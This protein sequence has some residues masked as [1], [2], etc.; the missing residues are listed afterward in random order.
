MAKDNARLIEV[1]VMPL[2][3]WLEL[4][5]NPPDGV[6]FVD[7]KFP[8]NKHLQE[9]VDTIGYRSEEE[10][11]SL[12][13]RLLIPSTSLG[14]DELNFRTLR[15]A[16][17]SDHPPELYEAMIDRQYY[18]RLVPYSA[19][20]SRIPPWEGITWVLDLLPHFPNQVLSTLNAYVLAH[21]QILPDGRL[22]GLQDTVSVIR[23]KF[24]GLPG[25]QD[26]KVEF[27]LGRSPRDFEHL[28]ERLYS[29]MGYETRLTPYQKDGGR[30]VVATRSAPGRVER[31]LVECKR[32]FRP[33]GVEQVRA[34]LGVVSAEKVNKGVVATTSRFTV[35]ASKFA[36]ENHLELVSGDQLVRL[37]NEHLGAKW[38]LHVDRLVT[39]SQRE[40]D[41]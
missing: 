40:N 1:D 22:E 33:I 38:P 19:G 25:T 4:L 31:L 6:L 2:D 8:T 7:Y 39:A 24:I 41:C 16:R 14:C 15:A 36:E 29:D 12:L 34:L 30:D 9:Y 20:R 10:V 37:M 5:L 27:L 35:P 21:A 26:E 18:R 32:S 13:L 23:A 3:Q 17:R 11:R 28:V